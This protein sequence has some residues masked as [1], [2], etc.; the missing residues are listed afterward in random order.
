MNIPLLC[1][2]DSSQLLVVDLQIRL[3]AAMAESE[4]GAMV[5]NSEILLLA[6]QALEVPVLYTEQYP[7]GLGPTVPAILERMPAMS[8]RLEKTTFSC[9]DAE[10]FMQALQAMGREQIVLIGQEAHVCI[11]QT[12]LELAERNF[13]VFVVED[14]VCSRYPRHKYNA[15][16]RMRAA[17]VIV[18]NLES[19]L[20]EWLRDATHPQFKTIS[21][22]IR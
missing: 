21:D 9:C 2:A 10:G 20:F 15:L 19:V 8:Q 12:A 5:E 22:L 18:T 16:A 11:L 7:R 6:A 1:S 17:G 13:R 14:L 4:R 3:L